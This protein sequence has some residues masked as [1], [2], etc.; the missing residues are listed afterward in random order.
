MTK[1]DLDKDVVPADWKPISDLDEQVMRYCELTTPMHLLFHAK[2]FQDG[3]PENHEN[4]LV[5]LAMIAGRLEEE[6]VTAM[7]DVISG[8]LQDHRDS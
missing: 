6:T 1:V 5:G 4:A 8:I 7:L 2:F 3:G